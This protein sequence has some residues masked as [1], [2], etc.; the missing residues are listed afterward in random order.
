[1]ITD[2]ANITLYEQY[3]KLCSYFGRP[4]PDDDVLSDIYEYM[5][6][7]MSAEELFHSVKTAIL[8]CSEMPTPKQ[9][10]ALIK[11]T[12]EENAIHQWHKITETWENQGKGARFTLH[13]FASIAG[14]DDDAIASLTM[15]GFGRSSHWINLYENRQ[16][17]IKLYTVLA[18]R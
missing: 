6:S 4:M 15:L 8:T 11:G 7:Q 14:I 1:M 5:V 12:E 2:T 18:K 10:V 3:K 16:E 17:F 13:S 9:L